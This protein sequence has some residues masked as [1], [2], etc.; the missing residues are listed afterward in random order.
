MGSVGPKIPSQHEGVVAEV[1][2][3]QVQEEYQGR[4]PVQVQESQCMGPSQDQV[5]AQDGVSSQV[6]QPSVKCPVSLYV[7]GGQF[8]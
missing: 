8:L 2:Q 5:C 1:P 7:I 6:S 3:Y 4:L